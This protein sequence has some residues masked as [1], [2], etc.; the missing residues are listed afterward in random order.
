MLLCHLHLHLHL[1]TLLLFSESRLLLKEY[2]FVSFFLSGLF[3][4]SWMQQNKSNS[5]FNIDYVATTMN[6]IF[7]RRWTVPFTR[8]GWRAAFYKIFLLP[9]LNLDRVCRISLTKGKRQK[10]KGHFYA[11]IIY[12]LCIGNS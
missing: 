11:L 1:D 9:L 4:K 6:W 10:Q 3:R 7:K 8:F 12:T 2:R 5:V